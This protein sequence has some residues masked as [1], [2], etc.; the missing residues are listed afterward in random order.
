MGRL[1]TTV[2]S[3]MATPAVA[4]AQTSFIQT[5]GQPASTVTQFGDTVF[6]QTPG[7][8]A[9]TITRFG[10]TEFIQTPG[11]PATTVTRFDRGPNGENVR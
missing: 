11:Q 4:L 5:P 10:D 3:L 8:P 7:Q 1:I 2:L 9:T 6:V